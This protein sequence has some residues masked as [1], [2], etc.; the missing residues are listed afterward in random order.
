MITPAYIAE[1]DTTDC[2]FWSRG[3]REGQPIWPT[4]EEALKELVSD[5]GWTHDDGVL[6]CTD[7]A[8]ARV[9]ARLGHDWG[10]ASPDP[11]IPQVGYVCCDRCGVPTVVATA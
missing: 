5:W 6:L 3:D 11:V 2:D 1:C 10:S 8:V 7:C 4:P 9:C